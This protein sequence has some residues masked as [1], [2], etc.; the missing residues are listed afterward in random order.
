MDD[1]KQWIHLVVT[2]AWIQKWDK[3]LI[4]QRSKNDPYKP[5]YRWIVGWKLDYQEW[6]DILQKNLKKEIQEEVGIEINDDI[7]IIWNF[8]R[9]TQTTVLYLT[10]LCMW[11]SWE[12]KPLDDTDD[13][14]WLTLE[15]LKSFSEPNIFQEFLP[16]IS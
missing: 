5:G 7:K 10:F 16:Y 14:K 12:A 9:K 3:Y 6:Y 2:D 15:E 8:M 1:I 11:K 13:V 4:T